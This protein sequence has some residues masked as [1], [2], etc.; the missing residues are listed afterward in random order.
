MRLRRLGATSGARRGEF[1]TR[2]PYCWS[3][4]VRTRGLIMIAF[5]RWDSVPQPATRIP[6]ALVN[7]ALAPWC[8]WTAATGTSPGRFDFKRTVCFLVSPRRGR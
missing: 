5:G 7:R 1:T 2:C 8:Y 4:I 6:S 3:T